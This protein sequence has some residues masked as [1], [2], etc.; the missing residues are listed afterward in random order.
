M[1]CDF[2]AL[3]QIDTSDPEQAQALLQECTKALLSPELWAWAI[4]LTVV[5][6]LVGAWIGK[7]KNAVARDTLLGA[8]LGPI[9]WIISAYLPARKPI[10]KCS[11]C[12]TQIA[13]TDAFCKSC[14]KKLT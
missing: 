6:A 12:G 14:G 11:S 2:S 13:P 9:G 7:K 3:D 8:A 4:G 10:K 1:A 5:G